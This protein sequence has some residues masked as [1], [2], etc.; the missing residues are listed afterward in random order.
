MSDW[1]RFRKKKGVTEK[2]AEGRGG[3][4]KGRD[5]ATST[6]SCTDCV[7]FYD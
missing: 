6:D 7:D 1:R 3:G 2:A 4:S 5:G